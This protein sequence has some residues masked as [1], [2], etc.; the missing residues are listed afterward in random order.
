MEECVLTKN[1]IKIGSWSNNNENIPIDYY[2][3]NSSAFVFYYSSLSNNNFQDEIKQKWMYQIK[4]CSD[5]DLGKLDENQN[6]LFNKFFGKLK[7]IIEHN[8]NLTIIFPPLK[9]VYNNNSIGLNHFFKFKNNFYKNNFSYIVFNNFVSK[10][11][12]LIFSSDVKFLFVLSED[13]NKKG[14]KNFNEI[15]NGFEEISKKWELVEFKLEKNTSS[16]FYEPKEN[17]TF[18]N[19]VF[20]DDIFTSRSTLYFV[21][22][23]IREK[24]SNWLKFNEMEKVI[25]N[26][27]VLTL[28]KTYQND[29]YHSFKIIDDKLSEKLNY[30]KNLQ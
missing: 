25:T 8:Q 12:D 1:L 23:K 21:I 4:N 29:D 11:I 27:F 26:L 20:I 13:Y 10:N 16:I 9:R 19:F 2:L 5:A 22:K 3:V 17:H 28:S 6:E 30:Q 18:K 24:N 7:E 14:W 15:W